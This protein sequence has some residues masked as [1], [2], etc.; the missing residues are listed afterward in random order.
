M[1][2]PLLILFLL[3][4]FLPACRGADGVV[5]RG[6]GP[7]M[8]EEIASKI[9]R[10]AYQ[11]ELERNPDR[12]GMETYR[13]LIQSGERDEVWLRGV[14]RASDENKPRLQK[15]QRERR[16]RALGAISIYAAVWTA[17]LT[18]LWAFG[19]NL[20]R[21]L[22]PA[23]GGRLSPF[24]KVI[25][26]FAAVVAV[27]QPASLL[28]PFDGVALTTFL[29]CG[30]AAI[31]V[32]LLHGRRVAAAV[33]ARRPGRV[34]M[35]A[36]AILWVIVVVVGAA[37]SARRQIEAYDTLLYHLSTVRWLN[38]FPTVPG[39]ANLHIRL[40]T[41]SAWLLFSGLLDN[42]PMDGRTA[43]FLPGLMCVLFLLHL[44]Y[45]VL[46]AGAEERKARILAALL[47]PFGL[48]QLVC[49]APSL[50]FDLPAHNL[51][52]VCLIELVRRL[53]RPRAG[54]EPCGLLMVSIPATLSFIIKPIGAPFLGV[55]GILTLSSYVRNLRAGNRGWR[56]H[57]LHL[58]PAVLLA[59]W[60]ARNA[61]LSGWLLF[62]AAVLRMP[63]DWAVPEGPAAGGHN[64]A[65]QSVKGQL[66][67]LTGYARKPGVDYATAIDAPLRSW[68]PDWFRSRSGSVE[69]RLLLPLGL[70]GLLVGAAFNLRRRSGWSGVGLGLLVAANIAFWFHKSPDL[71]YGTGL[72]WMW[73]ACG[74]MVLFS[75]LPDRAQWP[76]RAFA[77][78]LVAALVVGGPALKRVPEI[79]RQTPW[80][81]G[82]SAPRPT[83]PHPVDNGRSA[84]FM[85]HVPVRGD[86]CGDAELP[87]TPY[88]RDTLL[89]R[90][91]GD[92]RS[93]FRVA[94]A[95][96]ET[97]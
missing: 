62:P 31:A 73:F 14:L 94:E 78:S 86:Q 17:I 52:A 57:V 96:K 29:V 80:Q 50:Y 33:P 41:N 15:M 53:E 61:V 51:L 1:F 47:L 30:L 24:L 5:A 66:Q 90:T 8:S 56:T 75:G 4:R 28:V 10:R 97:K 11:K 83:V 18:I 82:V 25:L 85:V 13:P 79:W 42:G 21:M 39:L 40:G 63:V 95:L 44:V 68:F 76:S 65:I 60:M 72:F 46:F 77:L 19:D 23:P 6:S 26:G 12:A 36:F 32:S 9:V 55:A 58:S 74:G 37:A 16:M 45:I 34:R 3:L 87:C 20:E 67:V 84:P 59:G 71:R 22:L 69:L 91:P 81:I 93:G 70:A 43:W 48:A 54:R 7:V 88:P 92:L 64:A 49:L 27:L 35:A 89:M 38:E 2:K